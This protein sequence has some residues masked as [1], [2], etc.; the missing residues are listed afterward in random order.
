MAEIDAKF[1]QDDFVQEVPTGLVNGSNTAFTLSMTPAWPEMV[2][3]FVN[4]LAQIYTTH[5]SVSGTTLTMTYAP[6][7]GS[8][9][10]VKYWKEN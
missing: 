10:E 8:D 2:M 9:I 5:Y 7:T 4:G 6:A 1:F 3:L